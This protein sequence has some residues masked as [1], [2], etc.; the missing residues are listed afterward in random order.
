M[1]VQKEYR[2]HRNP[3]GSLGGEVHRTASV[4]SESVID[5]TSWVHRDANVA[6]STLRGTCIVHAGS[7]LRAVEADASTFRNAD[8]KWST[9]ERSRID[10]SR[11][12]HALVYDSLVDDSQLS[13]ATCRNVTHV[14]GARVRG[15]RDLATGHLCGFDWGAYRTGSGRTLS[16]G[17][18]QHPLPTWRKQL[19]SIVSE[20]T[21]PRECAAWM[22][23]LRALITMLEQTLPTGA[24]TK[25]AVRKRKTAR[26]R[27]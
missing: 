3:D 18:E 1:P 20:N 9:V 25:S 16:F 10:N 8:C 19:K 21:L 24:R 23:R 27:A 15:A 12:T 13:E 2:R 6:R 17:C 14:A 5:K 7:R 22:R 26:R 4:C 11:L